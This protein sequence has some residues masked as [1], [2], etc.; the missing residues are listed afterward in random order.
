MKRI[1]E[2]VLLKLLFISTVNMLIPLTT[3]NWVKNTIN[4]LKS[5]KVELPES[6]SKHTCIHI[7][8]DIYIY[9]YTM[10]TFQFFYKA[11]IT[12]ILKVN[13]NCR[14]KATNSLFNLSYTDERFFFGGTGG[15]TQGLKLTRQASCHLSHTLSTFWFSYF[16][17][18]VSSL[19][20]GQ[21]ELWSSYLFLT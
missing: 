6:V 10:K 17:S 8:I 16:L 21:P 7:D 13:T 19:W 11:N 3:T 18:R 12:W 14:Q 1:T 2:A 9:K 15:W 5:I 20:L 4:P